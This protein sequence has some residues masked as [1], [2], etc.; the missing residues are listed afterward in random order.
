MILALDVGNSQIHG[1][2]FEKDQLRLQFR[3][4]SASGITSDELGLF[5]K[6]ILRENDLDPAAVQHVA[7]CS[8]V[9]DI[10]HS[11]K[12]ACKKYFDIQPFI[13][14]AGVKTGLKIRYRNPAEIGSDR[15]ATAI[16]GTHL[17][18]GENLIIADYGTATTLC[19]VTA[20]KEHL[21]GMILPGLR[22]A[23][24]AL[25]GKTARL[26][27]VEIAAPAE[28]VGRST[29]ENI[30]S[31]LYYG[32]LHALQGSIAQI[33]REY[34]DG[35]GG[36]QNVRVIGTGGFSRMFEKAGVFDALVPELVLIGLHRSLLMN[37]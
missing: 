12:N 16:A 10:V 15:I 6:A 25:E 17:Y 34:F 19:V 4:T 14:Q 2:V 30:Q 9:P 29:I 3:K 27:A 37:I 33:K 5:L 24:E 35:A 7:L 13:L 11:L 20:E 1:G 8:V 28:I 36:R 32:N 26:P 22:L 18:P 23:M 21:G 31:G